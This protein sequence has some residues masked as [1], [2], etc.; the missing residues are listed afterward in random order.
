MA[1][2]QDGIL[3]KV[4]KDQMSKYRR[5]K[6]SKKNVEHIKRRKENIENIEY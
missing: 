3:G 5:G 2:K 4:A 6:T 1:L